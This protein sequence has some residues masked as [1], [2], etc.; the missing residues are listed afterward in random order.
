[1]EEAIRAIE[2]INADYPGHCAAAR[3]LAE[4]NFSA[5]KVMQSILERAGVM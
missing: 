1:M 4:E 3:K 5:P 2:S